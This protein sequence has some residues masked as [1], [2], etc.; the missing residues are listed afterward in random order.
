MRIS[1][2]VLC[3]FLCFFSNAQ[4]T[5]IDSIISKESL[6]FTVVALSHDSM[7]GRFTAMP[8][9]KNAAAF[10][11][12]RF[13]TAGLVSIAGSE[14]FFGYYPLKYYLNGDT[15]PVQAINVIGALKGKGNPD[16]S[17]IFCAHY[18]H[19][20]VKREAYKGDKD[21]VFNG[22]NDNASGVALLIELAKY[23][24][25][26]KTNRYTLVFIAFSGEEIGLLGS[27]YTAA[28]IDQSFVKTVIN[29]DMIGRPIHSKRYKCMVISKDAGVLIPQF[30]AW[31]LP[32]K[33]FFIPDAFPE[34]MLFTRSD[35]Y[36][37]KEVKNKVFF[38]ASSPRDTYYHSLKDEFKTIDFDFLLLTARNIA[39]CCRYFIE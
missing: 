10:I 36:A 31:L 9:T 11:A 17:I 21:S 37:F 18:D 24:A 38:T 27:S 3:S 14:D 32:K 15:I 25:A 20:G 39:F 7:K 34:E 4:S 28:N 13:K 33:K 8:E 26:T 19:L 1:L 30:N 2:S 6:S 23:Y 22:A 12:G 16:T 5:F 35:H 29:F